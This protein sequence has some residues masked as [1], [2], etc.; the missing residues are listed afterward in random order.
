MRAP[1]EAGTHQADRPAVPDRPAISG[2]S[3]KHN[4]HHRPGS[5]HRDDVLIA[6]CGLLGGLVL[7]WLG[8]Y[9]DRN[10]ADDV[11]RSWVL[12][13]LAAMCLAVL[14]RRAAQPWALLLATVALAGDMATGSLLATVVLFADSVYAAGLY[15][16]ARLA[17]ALLPTSVAVTV[18][19]TFG[20]L[21]VL[22]TPQV[23]PLGALAATVTVLPAWEGVVIR[24]HRDAASAERLRAE[25]TA[26]LAEMDRV[27]AVA[28]E[29][30]R[31]ARELHDVVANHLSAIAV[32]ST[33]ALS[34]T[35]ADDA[36]TAD[37]DALTV[38]RE[39]SVQ[40]L[41]EMR[42]LIAL[43]RETADQSA[44]DGPHGPRG[45]TDDASPTL[46][47]LDAL[48]VRA[49]DGAG[50][51]GLDFALYDERDG[52]PDSRT[53]LPAPVE[54]AA[55]RVVQEAVTNA[56]KHAA[57][58][59]VDVRLRPGGTPAAPLTVRVTSP[60][61]DGPR[62][63]RRDDPSEDGYPPDHDGPPEAGDPRAPG[64]GSGLIG[65]RER[66]E[67]L[68]GTLHTGPVSDPEGTR[69]W[70]VRAELPV[71]ERTSR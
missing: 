55:Y 37:H 17:R 58:G 54:L 21:A 32:H 16:P 1:S 53:P 69:R 11:G 57:P 15:G 68:G 56:L 50:D 61:P 67:L 70:E 59:T 29:R 8:L 31:M 38:I 5:P 25:Q 40:G 18:A 22:R 62:D 6:L 46:D 65:M 64:G 14:G 39:N 51:T 34:L 2:R 13:P 7:W 9:S 44:A 23:L 45:P 33:A 24:N 12:L 52:G 30:A 36:R 71:A 49:H 60:L 4:R 48:L 27:Q 35:G 63:R 41:A 19:V 3:D 43:L 26:L 47:A 28:S 42:R 66:V 20:L 10:Q